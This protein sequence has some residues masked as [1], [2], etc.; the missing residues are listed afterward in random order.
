MNLSAEQIASVQAGNPLR[1]TDPATQAEV[2]VVR[3]D[4]FAE[5][6]ALLK[7]ASSDPEDLYPLLA[8]L[9]PE[10]WED[11]SAYG[12]GQKPQ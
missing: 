5:W 9:T 3:A 8:D 6:Q 2:V 4:Q 10:D 1:V 12:L 7:A 11:P